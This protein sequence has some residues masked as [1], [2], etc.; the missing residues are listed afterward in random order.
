V[1]LEIGPGR[2]ALTRPLAERARLVV[3]VEVD[4]DL[5]DA[6]TRA[7]LPNVRVVQGDVLQADLPALVPPDE[8][9]RLRVAG[10]LPYNISSPILFRLLEWRRGDG[11]L[12]DA[13][14]MLQREVADRLAAR[15][16]SRDYGI[17][18]VLFAREAQVTRVLTLPPGAF[19]PPPQVTSAVVRLAF[20]PDADVPEAP[21]LFESL[22]RAVFAQRR[23][24]LGNAL[25]AFATGH[26][27]DAVAAIR[28]PGCRPPNVR[29]RWIWRGSWHWRARSREI[30]AIEE[31]REAS[32]QGVVGESH[33]V[34]LSTGDSAS[35]QTTP[36]SAGAFPQT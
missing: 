14:V 7:A 26:A 27:T 4:R 12:A 17:L 33:A 11:R 5:A 16:G 30:G 18:S 24:T 13:T 34:G 8:A 35:A 3:G 28:A 36:G 19:R 21:P 20:L 31:I 29:R 23:K 6:L 15:P 25:R 2:G 32:E 22:V 9:S 10:N 1:F